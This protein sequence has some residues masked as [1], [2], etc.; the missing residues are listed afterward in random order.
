MSA[1][2]DMEKNQLVGW[3]RGGGNNGSHESNEDSE[4]DPL[5]LLFNLGLFDAFNGHLEEQGNQE[6]RYHSQWARG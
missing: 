5:P 6:A 4:V 1:I 3:A 2:C